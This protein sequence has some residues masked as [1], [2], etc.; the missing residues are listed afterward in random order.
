MN[1]EVL[2]TY[3]KIIMG[4]FVA[5][6][7]ATPLPTAP[8]KTKKGKKNLPRLNF[9]STNVATTQND[10]YCTKNGKLVTIM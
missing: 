4:T 1:E 2:N 8:P 5:N 7:N 9:G 3:L 10:K 6:Q